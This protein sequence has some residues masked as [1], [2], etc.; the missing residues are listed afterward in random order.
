MVR[1]VSEEPVTATTATRG[2]VASGAMPLP[3]PS[4]FW[5]KRGSAP[6]ARKQRTIDVF[7]AAAN[8]CPLR[9]HGQPVRYAPAR[10]II[11]MPQMKFIGVMIAASP[12]G[13]NASRQ[14]RWP[15]IMSGTSSPLI[16]ASKLPSRWSQARFASKKS[17]S[18]SSFVFGICWRISWRNS[19]V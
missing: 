6:A 16:A 18:A 12:A 8:G 14:K 13:M 7:V 11:G 10:W 15:A 2:S 4:T 17:F 3:K 5:T 19:S 9:I 1:A